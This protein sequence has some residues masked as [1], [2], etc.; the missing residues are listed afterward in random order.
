MR[1]AVL[2][3]VLGVC[4]I[5][6]VCLAT[7][8]ITQPQPV[9][10]LRDRALDKASYVALA[11]EWR[12]YID[13][14]GETA[15]ALVNLGRAQRYSGDGMEAAKLAGKRAVELEPDNPRALD[16][17]ATVLSVSG[18][19]TAEALKLLEHCRAVA[20]DYGD[21][22]MTLVATYL[23]TGALKKARDVSATIYEQ[24]ILSRPLQDFAYNMLIGLPEGA[25][26]VTNGDYDT[27][28]PLALQAGR[29]FRTDVVVVNRHL[30]NI[31]AYAD[32]L[33]HEH[34]FLR[35]DGQ[36]KAK[37]GEAGASTSRA[38]IE[39]WI[40]EGKAPL[41]FA[42]TVDME[43]LG[44]D[45][46]TVTEGLCSRAT[47]KGLTPE[48]AARVVLE[49][50]RLDSATDWDFA[51]D[52]VPT[53]S[54]MIGANYVASLGD[55]ALRDGVSGDMKC[56]L[57]SKAAAIAEFHHLD[58]QARNVKALLKKCETK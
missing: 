16:F 28:P 5:A 29:N 39:R 36:W 14:H 24:R 35:P 42:V 1:I 13:K 10:N 57:L 12:A 37:A 15:D 32:S 49:R 55:L 23:R 48:E 50:Y 18:E 45:L 25:I 33:F 38:I 52:L 47:G 9:P 34:A 54:Q 43:D 30:L 21:G 51:W 46:K 4:L 20:P 40:A 8:A 26:L 2:L 3:R 19:G 27:F 56:R 7:E 58:V 41:Y 44:L 11:K 17:Y 53:V 22:L 31:P 6:V